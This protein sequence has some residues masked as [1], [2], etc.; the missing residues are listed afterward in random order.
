MH[1][2]RERT[3]NLEI[4]TQS[5]TGAESLRFPATFKPYSHCDRKEPVC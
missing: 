4:G 3:G 5:D 2:R 1:S